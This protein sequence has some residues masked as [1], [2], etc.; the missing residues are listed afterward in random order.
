L[1]HF[2]DIARFSVLLITPLFHPNFRGVPVARDCPCG[3][4]CEQVP[5][6]IRP[7]NYFRSIPIYV[8][9]ATWTSRTDRDRQTDRQMLY[10]GT[11][12]LCVESRGKND[13]RRLSW[14]SILY[15]L[16]PQHPQWGSHVWMSPPMH[17]PRMLM[18]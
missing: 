14:G 15:G 8:I 12:A 18:W 6:A 9:T 10:C 2:G 5:Q 17:A 7:W 1:H 13:E 3:D 4:Q 11:A 16:L